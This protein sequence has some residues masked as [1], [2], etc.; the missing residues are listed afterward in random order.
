MTCA[1]RR[2]LL[3]QA[4]RAAVGIPAARL[5]PQGPAGERTRRTSGTVSRADGHLL[6]RWQEAR[7]HLAGKLTR[8]LEAHDTTA[9]YEAQ[10]V[11]APLLLWAARS[12]REDVLAEL[13]SLYDIALLA[14]ED[15]REMAYHYLPDASGAT[16]RTSRV[17]LPRPARAWLGRGEDGSIVPERALHS[18]QFLYATVRLA[19][20]FEEAGFEPPDAFAHRTWSIALDHLRRW[21]APPAGV[22]GA[23]QRTGWACSHGAFSHAEHVALLR[24]ESYGTRAAGLVAARSIGHCN[25]VTDLDLFLMMLCGEALVLNAVATARFPLA[26]ALKATLADHL[27]GMHTL[28]RTR[29]TTVPLV[30]PSGEVG[31]GVLLDAGAWATHPDYRY[32]GYTGARFPGSGSSSKAEP[33][34]PRPAEGVGWDV[35]HARRF[36]QLTDTLERCRCVLAERTGPRIDLAGLARQTV[37]GPWNRS[38]TVPRFANYVD[39]SNGWFRVDYAGRPDYGIRPYG[40]DEQMLLAGYAAWARDDPAV[41]EVL[42]FKLARERASSTFANRLGDPLAA[43]QWLANARMIDEA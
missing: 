30:L 20:A 35:S 9:L 32:S 2:R 1:A 37:I 14:A 15:V 25:V 17:R 31:E 39:G 8:G 19:R 29:L 6:D 21:I 36:V 28:L 42:S 34:P 7:R 4:L 16:P 38:V 41:A 27:D 24:E 11:T 22:P 3:A 10:I 23:F 5:F 33:L 43:V 12:A 40:L 26:T 18:A 13:A